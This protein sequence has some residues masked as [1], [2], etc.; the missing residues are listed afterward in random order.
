MVGM[1]LPVP[2]SVPVPVPVSVR[3]GVRVACVLGDG[4]GGSAAGWVEEGVVVAVVDVAVG[5]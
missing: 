1:S 2:V 4:V 3:A 5:R